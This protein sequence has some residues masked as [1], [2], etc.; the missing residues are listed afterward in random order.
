MKTSLL[1]VCL[2][3]CWSSSAF[4]QK[5]AAPGPASA[6]STFEVVRKEG[7]YKG[8]YNEAS[9]KSILLLEEIRTDVS[10]DI[11]GSQGTLKVDVW[12]GKGSKPDKKAWTIKSDANAG[13]ADDAFY[14]T[15]NYGCCA[16]YNVYTWYNLLTGQ[17]IFTGTNNLVKISVPNTGGDTL[18]R[19]VTFHSHEGTLDTPEM[20]RLKDVIGVIEYGTTKRVI[21]RIIVRT[22]DQETL[23]GGVPEMGVAHKEETKFAKDDQEQEVALWDFDGKNDTS[24]L[25]NFTVILKWAED[26]QIAILFRND[27]PVLDEAKLPAKIT[28]EIPAKQK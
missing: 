14:K 8:L 13:E 23:D 15:T 20:K 25:S 27:S 26:K 7:R 28:V 17:K 12:L 11:E 6:T 10:P 2:L 22:S 18:D 21:H 24:S 4:A 16:S 9:Y 1:L 3:F 5:A 19:Y